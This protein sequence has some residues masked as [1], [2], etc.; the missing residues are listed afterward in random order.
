MFDINRRCKC[1]SNN[2][3]QEHGLTHPK[4]HYQPIE[5]GKSQ[6]LTFRYPKQN[7]WTYDFNRIVANHSGE[8]VVSICGAAQ[9][10]LEVSRS[11]KRVSR[12]SLAQELIRSIG[13]MHGNQRGNTTNSSHSIP[14]IGKFLEYLS[15]N[16]A[17]ILGKAIQEDHK[18][19]GPHTNCEG[20]APTV[21]L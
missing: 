1:N 11:L 20:Q 13:H 8:F 2:T 19:V 7:V 16:R 17:G 6:T 5:Q 3:I 4:Q 9:K 21:Q 15:T 10:T 18:F 12:C 14:C